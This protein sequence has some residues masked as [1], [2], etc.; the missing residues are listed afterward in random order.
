[1]NNTLLCERCR[2]I[3]GNY[4]DE[5]REL[6]DELS[7]VAELSLACGNPET[8]TPELMESLGG[9]IARQLDRRV[10]LQHYFF[11]R[12]LHSRALGPAFLKGELARLRATW[13]EPKR[14][15]KK[16]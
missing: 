4:T 7:L 1:M 10:I 8:P 3:G 13:E 2:A 9:L 14:K 6:D 11:G 15:A 12:T 5:V 16:K